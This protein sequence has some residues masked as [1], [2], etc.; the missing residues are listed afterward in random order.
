MHNPVYKITKMK[1]RPETNKDQQ[2]IYKVH[3]LAFG[4][5]DESK[6]VDKIRAGEN[7]IN[8]L[9]LVMENKGNII[10]HILFSKIKIKGVKDFETLALAPMAILPN[11]QNQNIGSQL[12]R[13]GLAKAKEL[14]FDAVIVL[15]HKDYYPKF[16]FQPASTWKIKCPFEV[17]DEVFMAIELHQG[18]L[19]EK[20]G[21][22]EYPK[23]FF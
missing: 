9:S 5:E 18:S 21:T 12:V 4:Q 22:V 14:N 3:H 8:E 23:E 1:I 13:A 7:Y 17:P 11:F 19:I 16:G 10:G 15:G 6:I 2:H 20:A